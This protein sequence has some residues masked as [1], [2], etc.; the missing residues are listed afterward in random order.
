MELLLPEGP[1]RVETPEAQS[2]DL[3]PGEPR[4]TLRWT[5]A[6]DRWSLQD[7]PFRFDLI[8]P[9]GLRLSLAVIYPNSLPGG[10]AM[11][12]VRRILSGEVKLA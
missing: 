6:P 11:V 10:N 4:A 8:E 5:V 3:L 1:W 12:E 2:F 9:E 7:R